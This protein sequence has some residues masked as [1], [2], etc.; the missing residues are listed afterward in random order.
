MANVDGD[1]TLS[2][3]LKPGNVDSVAD[4]IQ[5]EIED[6]FNKT[7]GKKLGAEFDNAKVRA[8]NLYTQIQ[9]L[10]DKML[11]MRNL[12]TAFLPGTTI[13]TADYKRVVDKLN[14]VTNSATVAKNRLE[15]LAGI[16]TPS[17]IVWESLKRVLGAVGS[18]AARNISIFGKLMKT[19]GS[20]A[21]KGATNALKSLGSAMSSMNKHTRS[22]N[23]LLEVG[24]KKLVQYGFGIRTVF[25]LVK[26]LRQALIDGF[27]SMSQY[28][29]EFNNTV[30][31]FVSALAT[32]KL[33]FATAFAPIASVALPLL[34]TLANAL[35]NVMN[36]IG[37]FFAAI[38]GKSTFIQAKQQQVDYAASLDKTGKSGGGAAKGLKKAK[39]AAEDY[40]RTIAGFDDVEILK[41]DKDKDSTSSGGS[42][43]GGGGG[44]GNLGLNGADMF[45]TVGIDS[46]IK[47][48]ADKL[49]SLI[50]KQDWTGLGT[51]LGQCINSIFTKAKKLISW[52]NLGSRITFIVTA[53]TDTFNALV[54]AVDWDLIGSTF[55][56]GINTIVKTLLL[57]YQGI[58]WGNLG[59]KLGQGIDA[60]FR[61]IN[62]I[63]IG[64][65]IRTKI[66]GL[67]DL[68]Y[69]L[70][71]SIDTGRIGKDIFTGLN[72]AIA[73]IN[74][75][76]LGNTLALGV[77]KLFDFLYN[78]I[79]TF[80]WGTT[81]SQLTT[82]LNNFISEVD[83]AQIGATVYELFIGILEFFRT[84]AR[85]FDWAGLGKAI[86]DFLTGINWFDVI[87]QVINVIN[88]GEFL[89]LSGISEIILGVLEE[90]V[91]AAVVF[92]TGDEGAGAIVDGFFE[93][94]INKLSDIR[95]WMFTNVFDP[96][97]N[98]FKT[99]FGIAS[100]STVMAEQGGF[101]V[102]GL[103]NGI[104]TAWE[105]IT[106][107]FS[108]GVAT[109][110]GIIKKG[111]WKDAGETAVEKI[112]TNVS[113]KWP[114]VTKF[115]TKGSKDIQ[116]DIKNSDWKSAG[117][118]TVEKIQGGISGTWST[119]TS[120]VSKGITT[121]KRKITTFD[122]KSAGKAITTGIRIGLNAIWNS[123][124]V[125]N[126]RGKVNDIKTQFTDANAV[127]KWKEAGNKVVTG[128]KDGVTAKYSE[129]TTKVGSLADDVKKK[130]T[131]IDWKSIGENICSGVK[132]GISNGW[133]WV[134]DKAKKLAEA[135]KTAAENALDIESP[136]KVFRNEIGKM[137]PAG[138][139][140]GIEDETDSVIGAVNKMA[141]SITAVRM[142]QIDIPD[143]NIPD[144]ALGK[145]LPYEMLNSNVDSVNESIK[146]L[147]DVLKY[148]QQQVITREELIAVLNTVLPEM[149]QKYVSFYIDDEQIARHAN[150][151]N[152]RLDYRFNPT[153]SRA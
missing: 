152:S 45:E 36:I 68:V 85:N 110:I 44:L 138:L 64:L 37:K 26:K 74:F 131:N 126:I 78:A 76:K 58:N 118:T 83:W 47:N 15:A 109:I 146:N 93:G 67:I 81:S 87:G 10:R 147:M 145:I 6:I 99:A 77:N 104:T 29:G 143:I 35:I 124:I 141:K 79:T 19:L 30:S 133:S 95:N 117:Q 53:I 91:S 132:D 1:I 97:I 101:I 89:L 98:A 73:S 125:T 106:G 65:L 96:F 9:N 61:D 112:K 55:A 25:L 28:S 82:M 57:L 38:T 137:I 102:D 34:T 71:S 16:K 54:E 40:Q 49:R 62:W 39:K 113:K 41:E 105:T 21:I 100:P 46:A 3:N 8:A 7:S 135:A 80:D 32:L 52:D 116:S 66:N 69:G 86:G 20:A 72:T 134:T 14:L 5:T 128:I 56:E 84:A 18:I 31:Q 70:L 50:A 92:F 151:G 43:G 114:N 130:F 119:V 23:G 13:P 121:V 27:G 111:G 24:F 150:A 90:V 107:F 139:A 60:L 63:A 17:T 149:L 88:E 4:S 103:Y 123:E 75:P 129:L 120:T 11:E 94:I 153:G 108:G 51:F 140:L 127:A 22:S 115:F 12:K 2:V 142:P 59:S 144:I 148:S 48:F 42:G 33:S 122:W 136:S